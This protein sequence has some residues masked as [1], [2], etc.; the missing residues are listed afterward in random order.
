MYDT[1]L[2]EAHPCLNEA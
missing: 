1:S 2:V